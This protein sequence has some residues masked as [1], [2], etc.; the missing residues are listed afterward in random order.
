MSET[1]QAVMN[2]LRDLCPNEEVRAK[3]AE[4]T[5]LMEAGVLDSFAV[6]RLIQS[7]EEEFGIRIPDSDIGPALFSSGAAI[8]DYVERMRHTADA[9]I[10]TVPANA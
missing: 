3:L 6:V 10:S 2:I 1:R 5:E 4:D 7:V 9:S 8:G